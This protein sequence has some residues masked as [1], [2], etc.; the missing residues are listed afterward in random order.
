MHARWSKVAKLANK[1]ESHLFDSKSQTRYA[2]TAPPAPPVLVPAAHL[3][4]LVLFFELALRFAAQAL[5]KVPH[6]LTQW[7]WG[8]ET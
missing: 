4:P 6:P 1:I 7:R 5:A 3:I 8:N 2:A